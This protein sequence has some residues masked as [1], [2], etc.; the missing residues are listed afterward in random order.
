MNDPIAGGGGKTIRYATSTGPALLMMPVG[1]CVPV[2]GWLGSIEGGVTTGFTAGILLAMA[3]EYVRRGTVA[4]RSPEIRQSLLRLL[5]LIY[6]ATPLLAGLGLILGIIAVNRCFG[7]ACSVD[8]HVF[9]VMGLVFDVLAL[10]ASVAL[11][12]FL[13]SSIWAEFRA[14]SVKGP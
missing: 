7:P 4:M 11:V 14:A 13:R 5:T 10:L 3:A 12:S 6:S 8:D 1:L 9:E 2:G